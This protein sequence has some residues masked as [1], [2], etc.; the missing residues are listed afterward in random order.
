V[1]PRLQGAVR[2]TVL[3]TGFEARP[4]KAEPA[5]APIRA[6]DPEPQPARVPSDTDLDIPA[7]LRRR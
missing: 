1:D 3:A 7:F 4:R 2:I 5:A 6:M